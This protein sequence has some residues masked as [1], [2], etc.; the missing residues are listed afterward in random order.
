MGKTGL[1]TLAALFL[2][3][4]SFSCT[5][6]Q[7]S[8]RRDGL[9]KSRTEEG[10]SQKPR[11]GKREVKDRGL[12]AE[13][14]RDIGVADELTPETFIRITILYRREN[15]VW[16]EQSQVLSSQE[17]E[18]YFEEMNAAFFSRFGF[19]EEKFLAY[20]ENNTAELDAYIQEH[21]EL[22]V[23]MMEE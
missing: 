22:M 4:M 7:D 11:R 23:E 2:L 16:I 14:Q 9:F 15:R 20:G 8:D 12:T 5:E 19:T 17:Q 10:K 13:D 1:Y 21:P 18:R 3:T 6:R